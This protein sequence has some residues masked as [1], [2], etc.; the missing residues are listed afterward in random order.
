VLHEQRTTTP[1][2]VVASL[3]TA[4]EPRDLEVVRPSLEDIYL[5]LV[6]RSEV[7]TGSTTEQEVSA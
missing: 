4:G 6:A 2:A 5:E 7:S 3:A 1:A